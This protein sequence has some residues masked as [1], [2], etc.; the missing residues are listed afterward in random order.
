[1]TLRTGGALSANQTISHANVVSSGI[2]SIL[3]IS[4]FSIRDF[5]YFPDFLVLMEIFCQLKFI[6]FLVGAPLMLDV[7]NALYLTQ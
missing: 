6:K 5:L 3:L 4:W 1:M 7:M 2:F